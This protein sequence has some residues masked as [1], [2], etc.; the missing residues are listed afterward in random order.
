MKAV[1]AWV[2]LKPCWSN[3]VP[4]RSGR[5]YILS[6]SRGE[7]A[8]RGLTIVE[9]RD[10]DEAARQSKILGEVLGE[11]RWVEGLTGDCRHLDLDEGLSGVSHRRSSWSIRSTVQDVEY[12]TSSRGGFEGGVASFQQTFPAPK[13]TSPKT[14]PPFR[15]LSRVHAPYSRWAMSRRHGSRVA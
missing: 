3:A 4:L 12:R 8:S 15:A 14:T 13:T 10:C 2:E 1:I 7:A 5:E 11:V 9:R 6:S